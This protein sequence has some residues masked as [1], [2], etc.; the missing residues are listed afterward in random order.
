MTQIF[1]EKIYLFLWYVK[2]FQIKVK[3]C[4]LIINMHVTILQVLL[5]HSRSNYRMYAGIQGDCPLISRRQ[6][7]LILQESLGDR[8]KN[9]TN[10]RLRL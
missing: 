3:L 6:V 10:C 9:S 5:H 1:N 2:H 4:I 8:R 7:L